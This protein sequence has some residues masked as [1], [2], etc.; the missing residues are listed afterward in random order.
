MEH[1]KELDEIREHFIRNL[2]PYS[3]YTFKV[4]ERTA[5]GWG[6]FSKKIQAVTLEGGIYLI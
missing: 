4:R 5:T 3:V 2:T 6:P 1:P